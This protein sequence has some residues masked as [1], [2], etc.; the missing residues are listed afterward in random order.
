VKPGFR[1]NLKSIAIPVLSAF[2]AVP[3][4]IA[5]MMY[6]VNIN[7]LERVQA[8]RLRADVSNIS[9]IIKAIVD[10]HINGLQAISKTLQENKELA[11]GLAYYNISGYQDPIKDLADRLFP[12]LSIDLLMFTDVDGQVIPLK[13]D[14][15]SGYFG[16]ELEL[17][18]RGQTVLHT[19]EGYEGW[20]IRSIAPVY[21]PFGIHYYG[22]TIIGIKIDDRFA[23]RIAGESNTQI[24]ITHAGG[25]ILASSANDAYRELIQ[26]ETAVRSIVD[27]RSI[28][29]LDRTKHISTA[30]QPIQV[31]NETFCL[32]VQQDTSNSYAMLNKERHRLL[33]NLVGILAAVLACAFWL[34]YG[35]IRPLKKLEFKTRKMIQQFS[36]R[37]E[38]EAA[39][40]NEIHRLVTSFD[41][42]HEHLVAYTHRLNE[43]KAQAE[44]ANE[45][46]GQFL[47]NMSHEIRTPLNGVIGMTSLLMQTKLD[48]EQQDFA[49]TA[50]ISAESLLT[51]INDILDFSKIEA[52]MLELE[53][54]DFDLRLTVEETSQMLAHKAHE[55]G[56]EFNCFVHPDVPVLVKGDPGRLRQIAVNLV[57]NAIKFT[58]EGEVNI[59]VTLLEEDGQ[60]VL[61][62][63]DVIDT[64]IGIPKDRLDRLFKSFSQVDASTTRKFGGTGLGLAISKKLTELMGGEIGVQSRY[65]QGTAF[66]LKIPFIKQT[67]RQSR[68][69]QAELPEGLHQK[70]ILIVDYND[71]NRRILGAYLK[72]WNVRY[73]TSKSGPEALKLLHRALS[74]SDP[75]DLLLSDMV[76]PDMNGES[77]GRA[78]KSDP[79]FE[80]LR[81]ILLSSSGLRGDA[82]RA[83]E[84][85][86]DVYMTKP[87]GQSQLYNAILTAFGLKGGRG[88][89]EICTVHSIAEATKEMTSI[90]LVEDNDINQKVAMKTLTKY[91]F[92]ADVVG[93]G[94]KALETLKKKH[95]DIVLMDVQMPEMD[96]LEATRE[97][98]KW[99]PP[100]C[101]IPI[102]ALTAGAFNEDRQ[103]CEA[104]G[105]DDFLTKPFDPQKMHDVIRKWT[106]D[107]PDSDK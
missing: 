37:Y 6:H 44:S 92:M 38:D 14:A 67:R 58:D 64:G 82:A 17:V 97:I 21:W 36:G 56:L 71:T 28:F 1:S 90:L 80:D 85:G 62:G 26:W 43:A 61:L 60:K 49:K 34:F 100:L 8:D 46:K 93:N 54:I 68:C 47:A 96:G 59:S 5:I 74:D 57:S 76:M 86:F 50:R 81:M 52:D 98:R 107:V 39:E 29:N 45:A 95:Y 89:D 25:D 69:V 9:S 66:R 16:A 15:L 11:R 23:S 31:V 4:A 41:F 84:A 20:A 77:L 70:H 78:V 18:R 53:E 91:G 7:G 10:N 48:D 22:A 55:K 30:Y 106:V 13:D 105:M 12:N 27:N 24:S 40:G 103:R 79:R 51:L 87:V 99:E 72:S 75:F 35:G 102:I 33:L 3:L 19:S 101:R 104:A 32:V 2:L 65:G 73:S 88:E 42:M 83:K 63:L 94:Q